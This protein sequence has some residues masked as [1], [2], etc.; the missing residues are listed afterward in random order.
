MNIFDKIIPIS[1]LKGKN[2]EH[3]IDEIKSDLKEDIAY[4]DKE[5]FHEYTDEFYVAEIIREKALMKLS[6][7]VPHDLFID[8][9]SFEL[10]EN[11]VNIRVEVVLNR[12]TLKQIVIGKDGMKIKSINRSARLELE[13]YFGRKVNLELFVKVR[14]D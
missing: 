2:I 3:L 4:Y 1:A 8:V 7:E 13:E 11:R 9:E 14:K 10:K 5:K 12:E 6:D